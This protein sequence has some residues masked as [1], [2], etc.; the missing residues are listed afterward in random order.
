MELQISAPSA[1][2]VTSQNHHCWECRR[3]RLVCD[4]TRPVCKRCQ[5][6]KIV[7]PGYDEK[8]PLR[9]LKPGR[10][11]CRARK[12]KVPVSRKEAADKPETET[13]KRSDNVWK[14][15]ELEKDQVK[16]ITSFEMTTDTCIIIQAAYYCKLPLIPCLREEE[17]CLTDI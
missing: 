15:S 7:C 12:P 2:S 6:A 17:S 13:D 9:W 3:R 16:M 10:V 1:G 11:T 14:L 8:Q 4:S 5:T